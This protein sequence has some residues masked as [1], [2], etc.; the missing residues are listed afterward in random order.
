M[1][2]YEYKGLNAKGKQ[3]TGLL[4]ADSPRSLKERL[5]RD[6]VFLSEYVETRGGAET[7]RAGQQAGSVAVRCG[8]MFQRVTLME[9]SEPTRQL[10]TLVRSGIPLVDAISAIADQ[11]ENPRFKRIM[12]QVKR[13]VSEGST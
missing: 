3:A 12:S 8:A 2:I 4:D 6:G 7:R 13:S 1:P 9:L 11:L 10:A 5:L